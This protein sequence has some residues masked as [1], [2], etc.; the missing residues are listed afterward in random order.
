MSNH[1]KIQWTD[2]TFNPWVGCTKVSYACDHCYAEQ[3]AKR[4]GHPELWEGDR[5][6]TT[7]TNWK[8][9]IKWDRAAAAAGVRRR[10]FP[11]LCDVFDNQVPEWWRHD[12]WHRIE[13]TPNLDWLLLTKRPQNIAAM[14]P[15][16]ETRVKPWDTGWP[17]VWLGVSAGNQ[18]EADRNIPILLAIPAKVQFVSLEPLLGP[19]DLTAIACPNGCQ[20]P[21]Y[22]PQCHRDGGEATGTFSVLRSGCLDMVIVGGER[23]PDAR[24]MHPDWP[25]KI[26]DDCISA[27]VPFFFKQHGEWIGVPDLKG[28]LDGASPHFRIFDQCP[29]DQHHQAV[30]IGKRAAG[31]VLDGRTWNEMPEIGRRP[32]RP[33]RSDSMGRPSPSIPH[34][35]AL[36]KVSP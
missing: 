6:R 17:N 12:F 36:M 8:Q 22:C 10:V 5:R 14:L 30:R 26:R 9:A 31:R 2:H 29:R 20:P 3:W 35:S 4:S 34:Q 33:A 21:E 18:E 11:S 32:L 13:Q 15:T 23:G 25:R 24:P 27:G 7:T 19:I 28:L 1:T 16:P